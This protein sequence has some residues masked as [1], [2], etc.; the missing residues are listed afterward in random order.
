MPADSE[1]RKSDADGRGRPSASGTSHPGS[2]SP[3]GY[4]L[5]A[6]FLLIPSVSVEILADLNF[7]LVPELDL[8]LRSGDLDFEGEGEGLDEDTESEGK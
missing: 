7:F 1:A 3:C 5:H 8:A 6:P 4:A 2:W